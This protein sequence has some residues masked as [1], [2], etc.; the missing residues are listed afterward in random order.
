M[1]R[2][3]EEEKGRDGWLNKRRWQMSWGEAGT[4]KGDKEIQ[5]PVRR[6]ERNIRQR[7]KHDIK[8]QN[9]TQRQNH[10]PWQAKVCVQLCPA[11]VHF[12][13]SSFYNCVVVIDDDDDGNFEHVTDSDKKI[14]LDL[15][16]QC[17]YAFYTFT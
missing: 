13:S 3:H 6:K 16:G 7:Q 10:K 2:H 15:K 17:I 5:G 11:V 14:A 4:D 8:T 12:I 9:T 1:K